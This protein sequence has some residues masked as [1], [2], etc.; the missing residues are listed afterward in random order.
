MKRKTRASVL[1][2]MALLG[3]MALNISFGNFGPP[4]NNSSNNGCSC[5]GAPNGATTVTIGGL[6]AGGYTPGGPA[7]PITLTVANPGQSRAGFA[8]SATGG[9]WSNTGGGA[10]I[11]TG[12]PLEIYHSM[13]QPMVGGSKVFTADW[14]PPATASGTIAFSAAGN[15]VN[16]NGGSGGD[17]WNTT[18][19]AVAL[20]V[21]F[22]SLE[23][24]PFKG[25]V[26][27]EWSTENEQNILHY[28]IQRSENGIEFETIGSMNANNV[29]T[30]SDYTFTDRQ[31]QEGNEYFFRIKEV[32]IN[33]KFT[34][35]PTKSIRLSISSNSISIYPTI[36]QDNKLNFTGID[37]FENLNFVLMDLNGKIIQKNVLNSN[38]IVLEQQP[39]GIYFANILRSGETLRST[40]I[41]IK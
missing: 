2:S 13:K 8:L 40:K 25:A 14:T 20:P 5:H 6:P 17:T 22:L 35:S 33:R 34:Y 39:S 32:D 27:I 4:P 9:S 29:E 30:K 10:T 12:N 18:S 23:L 31:T 19:G 41:F 15:A 28:E 38:S 24:I 36:V 16:N 7:L 26:K 37:N 1:I 21:D 3:Y 11:N